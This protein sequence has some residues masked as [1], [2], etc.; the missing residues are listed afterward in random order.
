LTAGKAGLGRV[1]ATAQLSRKSRSRHGRSE[2]A[3]TVTEA[4]LVEVA[5]RRVLMAVNHG[6][7]RKQQ[8]QQKEEKTIY[9]YV[10]FRFKS[11]FHAG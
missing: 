1:L 8:N 9:R 10:S 7:R 2:R 3:K 11:V 6:G 5:V 4:G